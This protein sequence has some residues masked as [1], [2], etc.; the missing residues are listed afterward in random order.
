MSSLSLV[1]WNVR[2]FSQRLQG[3]AASRHTMRA[4]ADALVALDPL[5][6]VIALQEVETRSLRGGLHPA[7]MLR[8]FTS[9]LRASLVAADHRR[10]LTSLYYPA[11]RYALGPINVF[12]TGLALVVTDRVKILDHDAGAPSPITHVRLPAFRHLKQRRVVGFARLAATDGGA[13]FDV[14]NTHLSLPAFLEGGPHTLP[15]RMGSGSNQL[16]EVEHLL[17]VVGR[18]RSDAAII[19]GDFNSAPGSR[20]HRAILDA[21]WVDPTPEADRDIATAGFLDRRMHIDHVFATPAVRWQRLT[22]HSID[23]EPFRRLSDHAP[24]VGVLQPAG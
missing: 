17:G 10:R 12:T 13:A 4:V 20:A 14:Y 6:D 24:K 5:P 8:R 9:C 19:V 7:G 23:A 3:L 11:H 22:T 21:G 2:Y 16:E 18:H 15:E 1:T